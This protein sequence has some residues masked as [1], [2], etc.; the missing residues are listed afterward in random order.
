[1]TGEVF[2]PAPTTGF[3]LS[4][5]TFNAAPTVRADDTSISGTLST[6]NRSLGLYDA[7]VVNAD[8]QSGRLDNFFEIE[9]PPGQV[10]ILD[11]LFRPLRG[12]QATITVEIFE[13]GDVTLRLY[14]VD[15]GLVA[16]LYQ[17]PM[18]AGQTALTWNGRTPAGS[19]VASGVY[20]LHAQGPKLNTTERIVV[21]K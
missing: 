11:N 2:S 14:T 6:L 10:T 5:T 20:L 17:G 18:P 21:I 1:M 7:A 13:A 12:G 16:T 8:D 19:V 3:I 15:G 4:L 9:L